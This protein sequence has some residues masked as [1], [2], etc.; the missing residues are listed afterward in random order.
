VVKSDTTP[1]RE[2]E[3]KIAILEYLHNKRANPRS[4]DS[5]KI[6]IMGEAFKGDRWGDNAAKPCAECKY[7]GTEA[8]ELFTDFGQNSTVKLTDSEGWNNYQA[9]FEYHWNNSH[10]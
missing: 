5:A 10:V 8:L 6:G 4:V 3:V 9:R 1:L 7:L 2:D